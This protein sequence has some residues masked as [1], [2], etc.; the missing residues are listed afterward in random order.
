MSKSQ[1]SMSVI[2]RLPRYYRFI[3]ELE[4]QGIDKISSNSL[5][6]IMNVTAS[7]VRQDLNCFG[8][9][10]Q[11]GYGYNVKL[12]KSEIEKIMGLTNEQN[13]ILVGLGN[14]GKSVAGYVNSQDLG[15]KLNAIF[16]ADSS[17]IGTEYNGLIIKNDTEL[18][19]YCKNNKV[20]VAF[21]CI[22]SSSVDN[23]VTQLYAAGVRS[24]W[25]FSH[26][27]IA[28]KYNDAIVENVHL[29][30]SL[31]VLCYRMNQNKETSAVESKIFNKV[32]N[33]FGGYNLE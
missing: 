22:P 3:N 18:A 5:A 32:R 6:E 26:Y 31:M 8:C 11:Q 29:K 4:I 12:L 2:R 21:L 13:T 25:N 27:D 16:E 7:Q 17:K 20:D 9:F 24:F 28:D 1:I 10:G 33:I 23:I 30:D 14:L 15:F 19:D